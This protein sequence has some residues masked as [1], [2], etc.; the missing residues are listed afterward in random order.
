[1]EGG[2]RLFFLLRLL[3][4]LLNQ[5]VD[6]PDG[7]LEALLEAALPALALEALALEAGALVEALGLEVAADL[8]LG[9]LDAE[10]AEGA[11]DVDGAGHVDGAAEARGQAHGGLGDGRRL[12]RRRR[13]VGLLPHQ[14][15]QRQVHLHLHL[16]YDVPVRQLRPVRRGVRAVV[17]VHLRLL[18]LDL[19]GPGGVSG[20]GCRPGGRGVGTLPLLV[21]GAA[22]AVL[23]G[24]YGHMS[25][26]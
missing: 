15:V 18:D 14:L 25:L 9:D 16:V 21:G 2:G 7:L 17:L 24:M 19:G 10:E 8:V 6:A 3:P 4:A 5:L 13:L 11:G 12:Q 26:I 20:R 23:Y 1:M 22:A